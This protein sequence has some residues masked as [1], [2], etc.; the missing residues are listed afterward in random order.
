MK[1]VIRAHIWVIGLSQLLLLFL[2]AGEH[3]RDDCK[4][5]IAN[6]LNTTAIYINGH[7]IFKGYGRFD[8]R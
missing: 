1:T 4:V 3:D 7:C 8:G 5:R 6:D 2:L